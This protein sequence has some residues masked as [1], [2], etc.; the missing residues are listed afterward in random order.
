M[1]AGV[2]EALFDAVAKRSTEQSHEDF[3]SFKEGDRIRVF[4]IDFS[5]RPDLWE[6]QV[7][8]AHRPALAPV[9]EGDNW[10]VGDAR[11]F[12]YKS[13]VKQNNYLGYLRKAVAENAVLHS[14]LR[15]RAVPAHVKRYVG[16]VPLLHPQ[17]SASTFPLQAP[18]AETLSKALEVEEA[19]AKE[20]DFPDGP[21]EDPLLSPL[22]SPVPILFP[23]CVCNL[24]PCCAWPL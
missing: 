14:L 24:H 17:T 2:A 18:V 1:E 19:R 15:D 4:A 12:F 23:L 21:P 6:G 3:L 8:P 7:N 5:D 20:E 16:Q 13:H 10:Q 11:G 9:E 22:N